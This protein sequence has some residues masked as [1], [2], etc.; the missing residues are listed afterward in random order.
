MDSHLVPM[1]AYRRILELDPADPAAPVYVSRGSAVFSNKQTRKHL[2]CATCEQLFS[3]N[4]DY[5]ARLTTP[6]DGQIKLFKKITRLNTPQNL[7]AR[8]DDDEDARQITY[9]ACSL[10]WRCAVMTGG[11]QLGPYEENFRLYLLGAP[12]PSEAV[13]SIRLFNS[14]A[15]LDPRG[16]VTEPASMRTQFGWL[17]GFLLGGIEFRCWVGRRIPDDWR[18]IS[19]ADPGSK[20][21]FAIVNPIDSPDFL[22]AAHMAISAKPRGKLAR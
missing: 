8:L 7:L 10:M 14:S 12:F 6:D 2:L 9:F 1:W 19:I 11:C 5:M 21:Y 16:W 13:L 15:E 17:H 20:N 18:K 3:R 4:E 22:A